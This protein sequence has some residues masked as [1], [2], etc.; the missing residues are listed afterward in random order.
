VSVRSSR[1]HELKTWPPFFESVLDGSKTFEIRRDDRAYAVG[2]TL[3]LKEW[4]PNG[5]TGYGGKY[6]LREV[7][8]LVTYVM[9]GGRFGIEE[10]TVVMGIKLIEP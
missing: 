7:K 5:S 4:D 2:D 8:C 6:T 3:C 1:T 10:H 9:H